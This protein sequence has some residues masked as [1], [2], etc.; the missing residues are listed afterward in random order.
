MSREEAA[1]RTTRDGSTKLEA[2]REL[3]VPVP[4]ETRR[5]MSDG[6]FEPPGPE[7]TKKKE[8]KE[9]KKELQE[10]G[11]CLDGQACSQPGACCKD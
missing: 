1:A 5:W 7:K 4:A 6:R 9:R 3:P 2:V 11:V 8:R 10:A